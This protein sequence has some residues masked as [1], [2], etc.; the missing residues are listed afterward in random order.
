L[1][2]LLRLIRD[3]NLV[4]YAVCLIAFAYFA[5]TA[6]AALRDLRR[7]TFKLERQTV[8]GRATASWL[9]AALCIVAAFVVN[10]ASGMAPATPAA[11]A[12]PGIQPTKAGPVVI[13]PTSVPT[14]N[15]SDTL[16]VRLTMTATL[17]AGKTVSPSATLTGTVLPGTGTP[18][19][20]LSQ[21][22]GPAA[23][24][25]A[26]TPTSPPAPA[27]VAAQ[28]CGPEAQI[29]DPASGGAVRGKYVVRG[30]AI[31]ENGGYY[32]LETLVPGAQQWSFINRGEQSAQ[33][34]VLLQGFDFNGLSPGPYQF[35]LVIVRPSAAVGAA[36][37][38]QIVVN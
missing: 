10:L 3:Y 27:P 6:L 37:Q 11:S 15:L 26:P 12:S 22:P 34:N 1:E 32:K 14:A 24:T 35:R 16:A 18:R 28:G 5:F 30:T 8:A 19:P 25:P 20:A 36:C 13:V 2:T 7:A 33:N 38:I 31:V 21:T 23:T 9:R 17:M 4:L 29:T